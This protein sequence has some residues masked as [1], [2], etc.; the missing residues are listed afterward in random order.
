[1]E[2]RLANRGE[3]GLVKQFYDEIIDGMCASEFSPGW[4]K[5]VY[6]TQDFLRESIAHGEMVLGLQDGR[7]AAAMVLN[8]D[9]NDGYKQVTWGI[10]APKDAVW[11]IH[12]LGVHP[13]FSGRGLAKQMVRYAI[14]FAEGSAKAIRLDVLAGNLPA[15][16]LYASMGFAYRGTV[17]MFYEDTGWTAFKLCEYILP[18]AY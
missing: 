7:I 1:M 5:D 9:C 13:D 17:R 16:R 8:H 11:M 10:D 12:I 4:E 15:E 6:P 14:D 3:Y 18:E 2:I